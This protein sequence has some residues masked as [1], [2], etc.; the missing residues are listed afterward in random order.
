MISGVLV[1]AAS[2]AWGPPPWPKPKLDPIAA[3]APALCREPAA[4]LDDGGRHLLLA[5]ESQLANEVLGNTKLGNDGQQLNTSEVHRI[6]RQYPQ[7]E[8]VFA[9]P[10]PVPLPESR[11]RARL[12]ATPVP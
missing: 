1:V 12:S 10:A 9:F 2:L 11:F 6:L 4:P 8:M 5:F 3:R 7:A